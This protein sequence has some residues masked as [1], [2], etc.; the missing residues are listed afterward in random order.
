M[1]AQQ[2]QRRSFLK[3]LSLGS[4]GLALAG[5][6]L[7]VWKSLTPKAFR[8]PSSKVK[9]GYLD[10]YPLG[11]FR[12]LADRNLF[13]FRREQGIAAI[14][15]VCTHLGCIVELREDVF[16][17]PCHGSYFD[18]RGNVLAGPAPAPLPWY[19]VSFAPDG[20]L[21]VDLNRIVKQEQ[22]LAV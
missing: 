4:L 22:Y 11:T 19:E 14:S 15:A 18:A 8:E 9:V 1:N 10:D 21:V 5:M 2:A 20:K 7:G 13:V 17:C 16:V 3:S 6:A 12:K